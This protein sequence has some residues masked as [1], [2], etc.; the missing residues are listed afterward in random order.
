MAIP[1]KGVRGAVLNAMDLWYNVPPES[2][3]TIKSVVKLIHTSSLM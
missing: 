3:E 1:G 2:L